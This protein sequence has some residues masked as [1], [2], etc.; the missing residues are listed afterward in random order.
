MIEESGIVD[1]ILHSM[2][3]LE[4][5]KWSYNRSNPSGERPN[6]VTDFRIIE[7]GIKSSAAPT[8][9]IFSSSA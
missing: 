6:S 3:S 9:Q 8:L 1:A 4:T 5:K 7:D 2:A